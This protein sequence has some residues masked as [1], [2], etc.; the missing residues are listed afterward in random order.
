MTE[1]RATAHLRGML[2]TLTARSVLHL[3][4]DIHREEAGEAR[5]GGDALAAEQC[6]S[7]AATLAVVGL[8]I[9]AARPR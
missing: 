1:K 5:R 3:L 7:V 6:E 2:A 4:A 9:D 8:G